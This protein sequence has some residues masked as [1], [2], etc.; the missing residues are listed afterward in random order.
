VDLPKGDSGVH[1]RSV[2]IR[3]VRGFNEVDLDFSRPDGSLAGWTVLAGRNGSGKSTLLKALSLPLVSPEEMLSLT[4]TYAGWLRLG[5]REG[6]IHVKT[7]DENTGHP[8][9]HATTTWHHEGK[10]GEINTLKLILDS[11]ATNNSKRSW[12][13]PKSWF[14]VGYGPYRRLT[15]HATDAQ[16]LMTGPERLACLVNL[17]REDASLIECVTWLRDIYLRRL[18]NRLGAAELEQAVLALLNDGLLPDGLR[19]E[20]VDSEGLGCSNA[21][22]G[23]R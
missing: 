17:F 22:F 9:T 6:E 11:N 15:G 18:E 8:F 21:A 7:S 10:Q 14:I 23:F 2:K 3:N 19:V 16:R 13:V 12:E 20:G 1:I 5:Q 4:G